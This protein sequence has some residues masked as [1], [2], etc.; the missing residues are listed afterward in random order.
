ML[1]GRGVR[2]DEPSG[3]RLVEVNGK[4]KGKGPGKRNV[5]PVCDVIV[6]RNVSAQTHQP[7]SPGPQ[8]GCGV[9][10]EA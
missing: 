9:V 2:F 10:S 1:V 6:S 8:T 3:G 7:Q 4:K 5:G